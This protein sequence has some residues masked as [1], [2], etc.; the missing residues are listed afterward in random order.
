LRVRVWHLGWLAIAL[1]L[2]CR[3]PIEP[4]APAYRPDRR[5][6]AAFAARHPGVVDPNYL[7]FMLHRVRGHDPDG[8]WL[9]LCRWADD[10]M[11][12][13]VY[14]DVPD[15]GDL[16]EEEL[17]PVDADE[18]RDAVGQAF[19]RWER[20]LEGRVTF[21]LVSRARDARLVVRVL[22]EPA[23]E[24]ENGLQILGSTESLR[25]AC[26]VK[27]EVTGGDEPL[28]VSFHVPDLELYILDRVGLLTP[29]QVEMVALHEI[30]HALGM[31]GHSPIPSD[32]MY[33]AFRDQASVKGLSENDVNSFLS[34]YSVPDGARYAFVPDTG[35]PAL[36]PPRPPTPL[37]ELDPAPHVDARLGFEVSLPV[38]WSRVVTERGLFA[39]DGPIWDRDASVE[40]GFW[41]YPS[42][43]GFLARF[44]EVL[45]EGSRLIARGP[46]VVEG[47][48]A[49]WAAVQVDD[50]RR[51]Q[52][53]LFIELGDGRIMVWLTDCP[54]RFA[55][56]W[57]PWFR[58]L[59]ASL[60]I[61]DLPGERR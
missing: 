3:H 43:G 20:E 53:F 42:V 55:D 29:H 35:Q 49:L 52:E 54:A 18:Y 38:G 60:E 48:P 59:L 26:R 7:P 61:W 32:F 12:L 39:A 21:H 17:R 51:E 57:R 9:F 22:A 19:A 10:D 28:L 6:D 40:I 36:P 24:T 50:D 25:G 31:K 47:H 56:E 37:P 8:D 27:G 34:L 30:G 13:A 2:G 16:A 23:P 4:H 44:G 5:D 11:P 15:L 41:P 58:T 1:A 14:I 46:M 33:P 45:F